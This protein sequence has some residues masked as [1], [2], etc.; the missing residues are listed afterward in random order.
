MIERR[1]A[2]ILC[3]DFDG[4]IHSYDSG[5][6][7]ATVIPDPPV[8]GALEFL[9]AATERFTV[10]I[11]STRSSVTGGRIAMS[12]WLDHHAGLV[13]MRGNWLDRIEWPGEKPPA[14][15]TLDDRALTFTGTWP[16]LDALLNF[17]PWNKR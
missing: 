17:K 2:P 1:K 13:G 5:W 4:V 15:V 12:R 6:K 7:G 9:K 10:A 16:D 3:L 14:L 8:P 11:Y